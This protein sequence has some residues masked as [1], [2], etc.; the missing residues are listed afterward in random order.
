[1]TDVAIPGQSFSL[2]G[3]LTYALLLALLLG[4]WTLVKSEADKTKC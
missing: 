3:Y 2:N 4:L 1:M